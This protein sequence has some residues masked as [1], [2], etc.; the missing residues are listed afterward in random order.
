VQCDVLTVLDRGWDAVISHP[1]CTFL[2]NS[3]AWAFS[4]PDFIRYPGV[5]YHQKLKAGTLTGS[6]RR[7]ARKG[8]LEFALALWAAPVR[9]KA[10]EN[11]VGRMSC[12]HAGLTKLTAGRIVS[13]RVL[14]ASLHAFPSHLSAGCMAGASLRGLPRLGGISGRFF[15]LHA[16]A[17]H[18]DVQKRAV[19]RLSGN[20]FPQCSHFMTW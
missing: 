7:E 1:M 4:D 5:G 2:T 11:P 20:R 16:R 9:F 14:I 13:L 15:S 6:A 10:M 12:A 17:L 3:A 18:K 19:E 8:A